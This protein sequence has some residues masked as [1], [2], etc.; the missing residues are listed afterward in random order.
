M[1]YLN[2]IDKDEEIAWT[3]RKWGGIDEVANGP[4]GR[5]FVLI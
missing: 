2:F 3:T 5:C 4:G 1:L